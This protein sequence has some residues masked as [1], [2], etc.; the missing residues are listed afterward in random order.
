MSRRTS[1]KDLLIAA[2]MKNA[3]SQSIQSL[4]SNTKS[5]SFLDEDQARDSEEVDLSRDDP[6]FLRKR[7]SNKQRK[8]AKR[9]P[10]PYKSMS[11]D[12]TH[13]TRS[14]QK[15]KKHKLKNG[16]SAASMTFSDADDDEK[17][18]PSK[19]TKSPKSS[20]SS[21]SPK[22][23]KHPKFSK[24][25]NSLDSKSKSKRYRFHHSMVIR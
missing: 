2:I 10:V 14:K 21:K 13:K 12:L 25:S 22:S 15:G 19:P 20:K 11:I 5:F 9:R 18:A 1:S 23:P 7:I 8:S 4:E 16:R 24:S 3:K 6:L 17:C